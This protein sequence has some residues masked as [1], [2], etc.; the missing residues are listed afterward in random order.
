MTRSLHRGLLT[1]LETA[2]APLHAEAD[3]AKGD[4]IYCSVPLR[5]YDGETS[6]YRLQISIGHDNGLPRL[7]VQEQPEHGR[8]PA[9]CPARHI[10]MDGTFCLGW[11][12]TRPEVP[13]SVTDAERAWALICGYLHLQDRASASGMWPLEAAWAHG[14]AAVAQHSIE[15][16]NRTLSPSLSKLLPNELHQ[17]TRR[18]PCACG[19]GKRVKDCHEMPIARLRALYVEM[20][21]GEDAFWQQWAGRPCCGTMRKCRLRGEQEEFP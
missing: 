1:L 13:N 9:G 4:A 21:R 18:R 16:I 8:L 6:T 3:P 15:E 20:A 14:D 7:V 10:N 5:L 19:S 2:R 11:G 17:L 12:P